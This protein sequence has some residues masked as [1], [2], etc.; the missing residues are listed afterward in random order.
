MEEISPTALD[1]VPGR[2]GLTDDA[3]RTRPVESTLIRGKGQW[4]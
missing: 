3:E 4:A 1:I 2:P